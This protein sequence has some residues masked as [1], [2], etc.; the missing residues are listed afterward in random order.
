M[1]T[2]AY[3]AKEDNNIRIHLMVDG[4][5]IAYIKN[6]DDAKESN[7]LILTRNLYLIAGQVVSVDASEISKV[8]ASSGGSIGYRSWFS[9]HLIYSDN[10]P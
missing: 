10:L 8:Q 4:N 3:Q 9:G 1:F 6:L 2:V 7:S 5:P